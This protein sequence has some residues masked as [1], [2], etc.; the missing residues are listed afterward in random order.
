MIENNRLWKTDILFSFQVR[1][2][3]REKVIGRSIVGMPIGDC[4]IM[5]AAADQLMVMP[6]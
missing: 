2:A 5:A 1:G 3:R 4:M 6:K